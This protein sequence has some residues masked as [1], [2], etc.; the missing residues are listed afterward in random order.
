[1]QI[2]Y[3]FAFRPFLSFTLFFFNI[4]TSNFAV[5]AETKVDVIIIFFLWFEPETFLNMFFWNHELVKC[6]DLLSVSL[7]TVAVFFFSAN[8]LYCLSTVENDKK[9]IAC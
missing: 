5:E 7:F 9:L 2:E 3:I 6:N 1:M 4:R 8:S